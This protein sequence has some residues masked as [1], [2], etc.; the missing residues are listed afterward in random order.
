M[1]EKEKKRTQK[2]QPDV[3]EERSINFSRRRKDDFDAANSRDPS[4]DIGP[5]R[6]VSR[7]NPW[8]DPPKE[9]E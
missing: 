4:K 3:I 8:P 2:Q 5:V 6:K 7:V 9:D 1:S